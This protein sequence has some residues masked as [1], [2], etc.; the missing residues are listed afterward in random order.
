MATKDEIKKV[1]LDMAGNPESG[2]VKEYAD[3]WAEAIVKIDAPA[4]APEVEREVVEPI[5]ETRVLGV[6][7]KR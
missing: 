5:K 1:I 3:V 4:E 2:I 6:A 7:E